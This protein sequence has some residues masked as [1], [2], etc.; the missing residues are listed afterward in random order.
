MAD[1]TVDQSAID[2]LV[3]LGVP[4]S[5]AKEALMKYNNNVNQAANYC[6]ENPGT[7]PEE[8][9]HLAP[10]ISDENTPTN[11]T[12]W[13]TWNQD[14]TAN[15]TLGSGLSNIM[16]TNVNDSK[17][18]NNNDQ[19]MQNAIDAS[20]EEAGKEDL[21]RVLTESLQPGS[22]HMQLVP[23]N[24]NK[25]DNDPHE[26]YHN[27]NRAWTDP[28]QP[29]KRVK[30]DT[31]P[32]GLRPSN[33]H[34]YANS[35]FQALFH[36]PIFRLSLLAFRPTKNEWGEIE[37]Y[38]KGKNKKTYENQFGYRGATETSIVN[39]QSALKFIHEFQRLFGFLSLSRRSYG[40]SSLLL[41]ALNFEEKKDNWGDSDAVGSK[42][43]TKLLKCLRTGYVH[44]N[45]F[46]VEEE[47]KIPDS[48]I[49][50]CL[51]F[52]RLFKS[53]AKDGVSRKFGGEFST[54]ESKEVYNIISLIYIYIYLFIYLFVCAVT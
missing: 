1:F 52:D 28:E 12:E 54:Y 10:L 51:N 18:T 14:S 23:Y 6:F 2:Q 43:I 39:R 45:Q 26:S 20:M 5:R 11:N 25:D 42:F 35:F 50:Y 22:M 33:S 38:W 37:G 49:G 7:E 31:A 13:N 24:K 48:M 44:R 40:D 46:N 16:D 30:L 29:S 8:T 27:A 17:T 15:H 4:Q 36:I 21:N 32:I 41:D 47:Q 19:E 3:E 34:Y 9:P 53:C